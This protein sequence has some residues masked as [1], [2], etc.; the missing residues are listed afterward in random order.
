MTTTTTHTPTPTH[1]PESTP[2]SSKSA[3]DAPEP[4]NSVYG[5]SYSVAYPDLPVAPSGG[6][7]GVRVV[8][9]SW[10][11]AKS[12]LDAVITEKF[13]APAIVVVRQGTMLVEDVVA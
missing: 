2:Q 7:I 13:P 12:K 6:D 3:K 10:E 4:V 11:E 5:F 9:T 8:A 1:K